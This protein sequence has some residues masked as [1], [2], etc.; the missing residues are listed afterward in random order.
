MLSIHLQINAY[1]SLN[2]R[3]GYL[4]LDIK[5]CWHSKFCNSESLSQ[6]SIPRTC[7]ERSLQLPLIRD[8]W[9]AR[10]EGTPEISI[11]DIVACSLST[12]YRRRLGSPC[13]HSSFLP[14][15]LLFAFFLFFLFYFIRF[16]ITKPA[17]KSAL[18]PR[19]AFNS[20]S[21]RL[22]LSRARTIKHAS[23]PN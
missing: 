1:L 21:A 2:T 8:L 9:S 19:L 18:Q 12:R 20:Q 23:M 10:L 13:S 6:I 4:Y 16:Y 11:L 7:E 22:S 17:F 15:P 14:P 5:Y 3:T